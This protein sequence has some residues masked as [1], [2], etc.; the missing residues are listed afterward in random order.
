MMAQARGRAAR[1][2]QQQQLKL[3][4][5]GTGVPSQSGHRIVPPCS[6]NV[7]EVK[8]S[9]LKLLP[10]NSINKEQFCGKHSVRE[11]KTKSSDVV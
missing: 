8:R 3:T 6:Y 5:T 1:G 10:K 7:P 2:Q 11:G 4:V 9:P